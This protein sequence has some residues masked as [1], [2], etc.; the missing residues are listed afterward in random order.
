MG[1][2]FGGHRHTIRTGLQLGMALFLVLS[3]FARSSSFAKNPFLSASG[4]DRALAT[5]SGTEWG[6]E[7]GPKDLPLSARVVTVRREKLTWGEVFEISFESIRSQTGKPRTINPLLLVVTDK[8]IVRISAD[9]PSEAIAK[10]KTLASQPKYEPA[11]LV[12]LSQGSK[13]YKETG[14]TVAKIAT[15]GDKLRYTWNHNSG[16]YLILEWQRGVGLTEISQNRGA[17]AD[18]FRLR[19]GILPQR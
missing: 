11:D 4:D 18:G 1:K 17:H 5:F 12:G 6:D 19:R 14:L 9:K 2:G 10:L 8:E 3:V 16:H 7:L 15:K 13:T